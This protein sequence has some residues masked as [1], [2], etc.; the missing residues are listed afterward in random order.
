VRTCAVFYKTENI[1]W[2]AICLSLV[3]SY[4]KNQP[5]GVSAHRSSLGSIAL[6]NFPAYSNTAV[7]SAITDISFAQCASLVNLY[8]ATGGDSWTNKTNW[9]TGTT[10]A[11]WHGIRLTGNQVSHVTLVSNNL[12]GTLP[13]ISGLSGLTSLNVGGNKL[14]G[15]LD[16][17][18]NLSSLAW[19]TIY[20]NE[21][22]DAI[23]SSAAA[24]SGMTSL[25]YIHAGSTGFT[26]TLL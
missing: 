9:L 20:G 2:L 11:S 14:T 22:S 19:L 26:G 13:D 15:N 4:K 8:T 25:H 21:F 12:V 7:C 17:L 23:A 16:A 18:G 1:T 5:R 10:A 24:L 3:G 6:F